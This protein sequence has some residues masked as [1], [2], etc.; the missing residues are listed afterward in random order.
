MR[1]NA[2]GAVR[3]GR[4]ADRNAGAPDEEDTGFDFGEAMGAIRAELGRA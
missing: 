4:R 3:A 1:S 2:S